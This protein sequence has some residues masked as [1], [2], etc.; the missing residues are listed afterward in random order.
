MWSWIE[1]GFKS[2]EEIRARV[3]SEIG[4]IVAR[5]KA[6]REKETENILAVIQGM[7]SCDIGLSKYVFDRAVEKGI[8]T[9]WEL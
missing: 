5:K 8:G 6:G 2:E 3:W 1:K 9:V 4:A 7:A